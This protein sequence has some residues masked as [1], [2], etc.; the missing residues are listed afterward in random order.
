MDLGFAGKVALVTGAS[1]GLGRAVADVLAAEGAAVALA[2]RNRETLDST[3]REIRERSA[4]S[5]SSILAEVADVTREEDVAALVDRVLGEL[6]RIDIL[7]ANAGGPPASRFETTELSDWKSGLDLSLLSTILLCRAVVPGMKE[8]RSGRIVAVTS[9]SVKQP[10][11]GLILSNTARAGVV[12]LMKTLSNEL[13][14]FGIGVNVICPGYTRTDRLVEL[15]SRLSRQEGVSQETIESRWTSQIPMGRLGEPSEFASVV[16]FLCSDRSSY[17]TG[18]CLQVDGG[19]VK[20][21]F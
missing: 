5:G 7:V 12:G 8:R 21:V 16:A 20:G 19:V 6:G 15:A 13:G 14:P 17:V 11:E 4:R 10:V 3:A 2:A 1:R 9:I 18:T